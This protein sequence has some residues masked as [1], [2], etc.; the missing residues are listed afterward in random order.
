MHRQDLSVQLRDQPGALAELG[1]TLGRTG[2]SLEGGGDGER[3]VAAL[4]SYGIAG[5]SPSAQPLVPRLERARPPVA[6]RIG[7]AIADVFVDAAWVTRIRGT[8]ALCLTSN[9]RRAIAKE[10]GVPS[11]QPS[12]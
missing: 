11:S 2:V 10:L 9:G 4:R 7:A 8:R 5:A 12:F 6:G 3:A 1:E